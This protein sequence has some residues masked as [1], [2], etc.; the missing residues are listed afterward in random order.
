M[1]SLGWSG[2][3]MADGTNESA[4]LDC[5]ESIT[6]DMLKKTGINAMRTDFAKR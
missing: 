5:V 2:S 6:E 4:V 3:A 1:V